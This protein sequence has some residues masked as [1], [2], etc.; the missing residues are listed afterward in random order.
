M[1]QKLNAGF[2]FVPEVAKVIVKAVT[3][4]YPE[5][6]YTVVDNAA[7]MLQAKRTMSYAEFGRLMKKQ[8][9]SQ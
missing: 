5:L 8:F 4:E 1:M 3:S 9:L 7:A 6:R 2:S